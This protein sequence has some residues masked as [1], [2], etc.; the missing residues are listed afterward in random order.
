[1]TAVKCFAPLLVLSVLA[2]VGGYLV[3]TAGEPG[4]ALDPVT[5]V[6]GVVLWS[7]RLR[8]QIT[9]R[10]VGD[11]SASGDIHPRTGR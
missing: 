6:D 7:R 2:A 11:R 1:M 8:F 9:R 4:P 10:V 3:V 5:T